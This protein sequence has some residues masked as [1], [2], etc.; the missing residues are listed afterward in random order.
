MKV[1]FRKIPSWILYLFIHFV[2]L[3]LL[4]SAFR[5]VFF[6]QLVNS[7]QNI[8]N[9][10]Y[11]DAF[12]L[13]ISFDTMVSSYLL[14]IP[15]LAFFIA[16]L[17]NHSSLWLRRS[18]SIYFG[19]IFFAVLLACTAD[20]PFYKFCGSRLSTAIVMWTDTP[21]IMMKFVME[22]SEYYS[23]MTA[24]FSGLIISVFLLLS[25]HKKLLKNIFKE[26]Y[27][28]KKKI[29]VFVCVSFSLLI[30]I[31]GGW[32]KRPVAIRDAFVTNYPFVN[33][34]PLNPVHSFFDSMQEIYLHYLDDAVAINNARRY[35]NVHDQFNSPIARKV[36]FADSSSIK[37]NIVFVLM[38]SM[39]AEM[40]G[41]SSS[42]KSFTPN[43]DS[44]TKKSIS[45]SRF[46]TCG[47]HTSNGLYGMLY[48]MPSVPGEHPISNIYTVNQHFTGIASVLKEKG[49]S[50]NF[51]CTH[52]EEFD[53]MG[54][55]LRNNGFDNFFSAKEYKSDLSEGIFGVSDEVQYDFAFNK[56]NDFAKAAN[57]FFATMLT[58]STHEPQILPRHTS[59]KPKSNDSF[60]QVYEY[61]DWALGNFLKRCSQE[62][63][64][65]NTIFVFVADHGCNMESPYE[66]PLSYHHSPFIIYAPS[67]IKEPKLIDK[68]AIQ[69]DVFPT[70]MDLLKIPYTNNTLGINLFTEERPYV[71]FCKDY[72]VGCL[73]KKHFLIIQKFGGESMYD[74]SNNSEKNV[75]ENNKTL[76]DSMKTYT[77]SMLQTAQWLLENKKLGKQ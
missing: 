53:N 42:G 25:I 45:F 14:L 12:S 58:I 22:N 31:R 65:D 59:F 8:S 28:V 29:I 55:F 23:Y 19:V 61:A 67:L 32:R 60:E 3:L 66:I 71:F 15:A 26:K 64:Y 18:I 2:V 38:E 56:L 54:F 34:L 57:P 73:D 35:L 4:F 63:W 24:F 47:M 1:L 7:S 10:L 36:L 6:R 21:G 33:L 69:T 37:P 46:Y 44:I 13:G 74:Y 76:L 48:S 68:L 75:L 72:L 20:I 16:M 62:K 39:S 50:T 70:L 43:L 52:W 41:L 9:N 40:T 77:Y 5:Y 51:F 27:S 30:G 17:F 11:D 49:Y